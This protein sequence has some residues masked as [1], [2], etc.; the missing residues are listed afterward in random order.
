MSRVRAWAAAAAAAVVALSGCTPGA[1][2]PS[3]GPGVA[4]ELRVL[5]GSEIRDLEPILERA[6]DEVGVTVHLDYTGTL[7]GVEEVVSGRTDDRYDAVWFS[8]NR[9]LNL[10]P[11][12]AEAVAEE[13]PVMASPVV[14][15]VTES[16]AADL[17]WAGG[18]EVT[19]GDIAEAASS[20]DLAF[21]MT[22]PAAS[23]SGFSALV[24]VASALADTG[25]ALR[26]EDVEAV[27][28]QLRAFFSG[29]ELT[30][31]SSGW[32]ADAYIRRAGAEGSGARVDA[33]IN[34]ESV[35]LS[36]N[37][38][39]DLPE[40]L[41]LIHP[42]DGAVTADYPLSLLAGA[43][44]GVAEGYGRLVDHLLSAE[45]QREITDTTHRRPLSAEVSAEV[46]FPQVAELP[47]PAREEVAT[48]LVR[49]YFDELRRPARTVYVLDLSGSMAGDR[50]AG[51]RTAMGTLT[52]GD[53][54]S[55]SGR[56]QRFYGR[57]RVTLLPF[58]GT[59]RPAETFEVPEEDP[60]PVLDDI[61]AAVEAMEPAG[62][63][64]A[65]SALD[66]A[67]ER[68]RGEDDVADRFTSVVLMTDGEVN[69]GL[70]LEEFR[71]EHAGLPAELREVP[72]FPVVFGES[73][74][75]EL[76]E[77]AELT[78]GRAFDAR[79]DSLDQAFR[80]IRGYQ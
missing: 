62:D 6:A 20:G 50:I 22:N 27:A 65:Y 14:L 5:A 39:W 74:P 51:M 58:D 16:A 33:L 19:W 80:E 41:T 4:G 30:A 7:E 26:Q 70:T 21:G 75:A 59:V 35:L 18:A 63:T 57:E 40:P 9:Y 71:A 11:G 49:S 2:G 72:V 46:E 56:F 66:E 47:F 37:E 60:G 12:G 61:Q 15:G 55:V 69:A 13:T 23:N 79:E 17:G 24:G 31:G 42:A 25:S 38:S 28:P 45:V 53:T 54:S 76:E 52:G 32:L 44:E 8:S 36:L 29:Q 3:A 78:G 10:Q 77:L 43:D 48:G 64:A 1:E 34:Y 73:D 67:F 68:L